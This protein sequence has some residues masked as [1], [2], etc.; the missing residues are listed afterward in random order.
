MTGFGSKNPCFIPLSPVIHSLTIGG[1]FP[2]VPPQRGEGGAE[3]RVR[4]S[5]LSGKIRVS[6]VSIYG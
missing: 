1:R 4:G 2:L 5:Y 6:S 3:R